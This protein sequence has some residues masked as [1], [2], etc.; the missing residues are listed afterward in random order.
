MT[1]K[2]DYN[3]PD[4]KPGLVFIHVPKTGGTSIEYLI[5]KE[6]QNLNID[7]QRMRHCPLYSEHIPN[8][9]YTF[10]VFRNPYERAFSW[11][12]ELHNVVQDNRYH[13]LRGEYEKGFEWVIENR[14]D[15]FVRDGDTP[16]PYKGK[17]PQLWWISKDGQ[18][19]VDDL[20]WLDNIDE[21]FKKVASKITG[22]PI[23]NVP[24]FEI[25]KHNVGKQTV[26][27]QYSKRAKQII[28][29]YYAEDIEFWKEQ[30]QEDPWQDSFYK[31]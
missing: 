1:I 25:P 10:A 3:L 27:G 11:Y 18:V 9:H 4:G 6:F 15:T 20:L 8:T 16:I 17:F 30:R 22:L 24:P 21:D 31:S 13:D 7:F 5:I 14:F 29:D 19:A 28:D 12:N 26:Y 23:D 2:V